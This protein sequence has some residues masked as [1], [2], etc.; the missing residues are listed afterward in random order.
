MLSIS[1][2]ADAAERFPRKVL[3]TSHT[4]VPRVITIDKHPAYSVAFEAFL[5]ERTLPETCLLRPCKYLSN[6]VEQDHRFIKRRVNPGFGFGAFTTVQR[7][8]QGY[9]VIH[10]FHK[11]QIEGMAKRDV[12]TQNRV[13]NLLFGL[14]V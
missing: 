6:V 4:T 3:G 9:E 2:D 14:A 8:I 11:G 10:M 7:T 13:I 1:C 12:L 5:Q